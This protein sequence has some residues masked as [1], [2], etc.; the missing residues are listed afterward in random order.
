M[1]QWK[2]Q[3]PTNPNSTIQKNGRTFY[4]CDIC[5]NWTPTHTTATHTGKNTKT[6]GQKNFALENFIKTFKINNS[7]TCVQPEGFLYT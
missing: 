3:K 7:E 5:G 6:N 2:L 4:W 1:S